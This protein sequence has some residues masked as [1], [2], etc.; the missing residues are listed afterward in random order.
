MAKAV[1]D[2]D[3]GWDRVM[4]LFQAPS[5]PSVKIGVQG[6]EAKATHPGAAASLTNGM[7][8]GIH[9]FGVQINNGFGRGIKITIPERSFIRSTY[10]ANIQNYAKL[11]RNGA[12]KVLDGKLTLRQ[13]MLLIGEKAVSDMKRTIAVG[14]DPPIKPSTIL[15]R[16]KRF[17]KAS[18]TPL[19]ASGELQNS[20]TAVIEQTPNR[21]GLVGQ[22]A[23]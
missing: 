15:A 17:G 11:L 8:A 10:D 13:V 9:E 16:K 14:I 1:T 22:G 6:K 5:V 21:G 3:K 18:T 4:S 23:G 19:I 7:L 2:V 20:I 12:G